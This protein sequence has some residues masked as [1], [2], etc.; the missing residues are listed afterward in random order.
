[1]RPSAEHE[2]GILPELNYTEWLL[3]L[4]ADGVMVGGAMLPLIAWRAAK[5]AAARSV[6]T[7]LCLISFAAALVLVIAWLGRRL[8]FGVFGS[9]PFLWGMSGFVL[10]GGFF[11]LILGTFATDSPT[12]TAANFWRMFVGTFVVFTA[13]GV[14]FA[15]LVSWPTTLWLRALLA[16]MVLILIVLVSSPIASLA[17]F[18]VRM[19]IRGDTPPPQ[20]PR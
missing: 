11:A 12:S 17:G 16:P 4:A 13:F 9:A 5:S 19:R 14:P 7:A 20:N 10:I 6:I 2:S 1:M 8:G 18:F 3:A 15:S